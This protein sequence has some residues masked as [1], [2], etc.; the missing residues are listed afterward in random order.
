MVATIGRVLATGIV[1][2]LGFGIVAG[3]APIGIGQML[4]ACLGWALAY[5]GDDL[6]PLIGVTTTPSTSQYVEPVIRGIGWLFLL[7]A[8]G[9]FVARTSRIW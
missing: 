4:M 2:A 9:L 1:V 6:A 8:F 5:F 7:A 3:V